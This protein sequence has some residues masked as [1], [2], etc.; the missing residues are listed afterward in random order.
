MQTLD[1]MRSMNL[2]TPDQHSEIRAW[3]KQARTPEKII[4]MPPQ[5]W[6]KLELACVL[7]G[8]DVDEGLAA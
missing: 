7:M 1:V 8:F 3:T 6:R 5:L 4:Q 2:L